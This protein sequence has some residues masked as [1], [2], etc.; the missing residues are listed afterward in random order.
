MTADFIV[1]LTPDDGGA[2]L[3]S[4]RKK[5]FKFYDTIPKGIRKDFSPCSLDEFTSWKESQKSLEGQVDSFYN[6]M[7]EQ[8][9]GE[10][11]PSSSVA[12]D[13]FREAINN[14]DLAGFRD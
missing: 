7:Y 6:D 1:V 14:N 11:P 8:Q 9:F 3:F 4:S 5:A 13:K 2:H 12:R 10:A